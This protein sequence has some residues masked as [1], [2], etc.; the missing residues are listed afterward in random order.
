MPGNAD[1]RSA[2]ARM[3]TFPSLPCRWRRCRPAFS[4]TRRRRTW[5][6]R[7][8][9]KIETPVIK[10]KARGGICPSTL[11]TLSTS[12]R[13]IS[14]LSFPLSSMD[15]DIQFL[16]MVPPLS[17][18]KP[19]YAH[20]SHPSMQPPASGAS[21]LRSH[22]TDSRV[23]TFPLIGIMLVIP[24][25]GD[26]PTQTLRFLKS[27]SAVVHIG[28]AS[29]S[30]IDSDKSPDSIQF[31]CPVISR[32]HAKLMFSSGH[33]RRLSHPLLVSAA[34]TLHPRSHRSTSSTCI[35]ITELTFLDGMRLYIALW[36]PMSRSPSRTATH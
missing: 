19:S 11:P 12:T 34:L 31:R 26:E 20:P 22:D 35:P 13:P 24:K 9:S 15:D 21:A 6:K 10:P 18:H 27:R 30:L 4:W 2:S 1:V 5:S 3:W 29:S 8:D 25:S 32:R 33:V 28:R 16:G 17:P 36:S 14:A 23:L 7:R